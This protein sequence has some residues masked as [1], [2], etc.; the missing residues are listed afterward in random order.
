[1]LQRVG[2]CRV[3][4]RVR[5]VV[6][7]EALPRVVELALGM[8]EREQHDHED[9]QEQVEQYQAT[10]DAQDQ[11]A[12]FRAALDPFGLRGA[13]LGHCLGRHTRSSV[14]SARVYSSTPTRMIA[15]N[16]MLSAAAAG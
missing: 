14:P 5:P 10:D 8:V 13:D 4:E 6:Q 7:G 2:Q 16:T 3:L 1:E 9:R 12:P 11:I 15:I